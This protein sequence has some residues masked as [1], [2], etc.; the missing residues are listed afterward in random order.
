M[1]LEL[2][3]SNPVLVMGVAITAFLLAP[4]ASRRLRLPSLVVVIGFGAVVGPNG[5]GLLA[6]GETMVL[7]GTVGLLYLMF[8]AGLEL[9]LQGFVRHRHGSL[10]FG[11]LSFAL[12]LALALLAGP[13][14]GF[15]WE[16]TLLVGA[17]VAS[18]TL[19][20]YP[21]VTRLGLARSPGVTATVGGT[22]LTDTLSLG[23]LAVVG[24][25]VGGAADEPLF[26]LRLLGGLVA[27]ALAVTLVLPRLG[28]AFFRSTDAE[29]AIRYV[30]LLA[31]MFLSAALAEI[32]GAQP[33]IG[34]FL[35]G[36]ALNRLAPERSTVMARVRFVGDA[37]FIPF[38]LLSVGMLVDVRVLL[39]LEV[40]VI[41]AAL[42]AIVVLGK[43]GAALL[44]QRLLGL[45]RRE[46]VVMAG[47]SIP[48]AAATL[49]VTF[50][51]LDL[52]LFGAEVV[53]AVIGLILVSV[54]VGAVLVERGGRALVL[55]RQAAPAPLMRVHRT[56]IPLANPDTAERLLE[57]AFL[58]R[59]RASDEAVYPLVVVP[60]EARVETKVA[61]A[62][63]VLAHAVVVAAEADVPV[64][65]L[66]RV[67][68]NPASGIL[69]AAR[70]RRI[71]DIIIG[72]SGDSSA[73]RVVFG[74]VID[75]VI[76]HGEEQVLVCRLDH[77]I[78]TSRALFVVLPPGID[79]GPGFY[80]AA[81]TLSQ[82][83]AQLGVSMTG[84]AVRADPQRLQ[85]CFDTIGGAAIEVES[86]ASW[87]A[88]LER[89]R[90]EAR[91]EDLVT[92][93][94]ARH[95]TVAWTPALERLPGML[96][97]LG[98]SFLAVYPSERSL[99]GIVGERGD[100]ALH[101][102][103]EHVMTDLRG[104]D[105]DTA[106]ASLLAC[107]LEPGSAAFA[108][109][110]RSLASDDVGFAAEVVPQTLIAHARVRGVRRRTVLIGVHRRGLAHPRS[111]EPI[112]RVALLLSP[113]DHDVAVHL[114]ALAALAHALHEVGPLLEASDADPGAIAAALRDATRG[115]VEASEVLP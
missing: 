94:S 58:L 25:S 76:A 110:L 111:A 98:T 41:A 99:R 49:A 52:G 108:T 22:L 28:R 83:A 35:A 21:I 2:P 60:D 54:L 50:V 93:I 53:N 39:S 24:A 57:V 32:A 14:L 86:V 107:A 112:R 42:I 100:V 88:L 44:T 34:A 59:E 87:P 89:L 106:V 4:F 72:W 82:L 12:P 8:V 73:R 11:L 51:G 80:D 45:D 78:A 56:L 38:F 115:G 3:F 18:H 113:I 16:A 40:V 48:Q 95:G 109:S 27:Y 92:V 90:T 69:S 26:W 96:A 43:G 104:D 79:Y 15:G 6:R 5:L 63:R 30:F 37:V 1:T 62:E 70:E 77:P 66:T 91:P 61:A 64:T 36:L 23:L 13:L 81:R 103:R 47:L 71:T 67:A 9:D 84:L 105:L 74:G 114:T 97:A 55:A 68:T 85:R 10:A 7:L 19:L 102:A 29:A 20:A 46:G 33:I 75:Q 101:V 17:I 65:A 31:A